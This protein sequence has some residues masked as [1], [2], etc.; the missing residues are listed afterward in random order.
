LRVYFNWCWFAI[1]GVYFA[2]K[3]GKNQKAIHFDVT[4]QQVVVGQEP[5]SFDSISDVYV[6]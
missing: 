5:L 4:Q 1:G 3:R 6:Q 2:F